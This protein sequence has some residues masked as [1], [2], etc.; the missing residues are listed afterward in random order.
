MNICPAGVDLFHARQTDGRTDRSDKAKS[1][2]LNFCT[3][4]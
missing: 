2:Y 3:R 1:P 4:A